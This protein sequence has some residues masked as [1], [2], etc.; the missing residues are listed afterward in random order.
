MKR[1]ALALSFALSLAACAKGGALDYTS[2]PETRWRML[3]TEHERDRLRNWRKAWVE[4]L[5]RA[6]AVDA[7]AIGAGGVLFEPDQAMTNAMPPAG[8]YRCRTF[9]LGAKRPGLREFNALP[10]QRCRIGRA[11]DIPALVQLDGKQRP[12]GRLY[13]DTEARVVFLGTLELGDEKVPLE[14]GLDTQRNM[15]GYVER[16]GVSRWRLVL[17]WPSFESQLDVVEIVPA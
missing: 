12:M 10:W 15:A 3:T 16:I 7:A 2:P 4:A 9:K 6:R 13:A 14:Y 17:P 5:P 8:D 11:G 1:F